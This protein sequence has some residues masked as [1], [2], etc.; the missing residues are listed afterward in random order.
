MIYEA[1]KSQVITKL[2]KFLANK[3]GQEESKSFIRELKTLQRE[4]NLPMSDI[5]DKD[6]KYLNAKK[7]LQIKSPENWTPS[8]NSM[9][10]DVYAFKFW[11][12]IEKGF[13]GK[14]GIGMRE[15]E[16]GKDQNNRNRKFNEKEL[17]FIKNK[18]NIKKG[19]LRPV[20]NYGTLRNGQDVIGIFSDY[21]DMDNLAKAR[22]YLEDNH[23]FAIQNV[24]SGG[25]PYAPDWRRFGDYSWSLGNIDSIGDDHNL[26]HTYTMTDEDLHVGDDIDVEEHDNPLNW[27]LPVDD[28]FLYNWNNYDVSIIENADFCIVFYIDDVIKRGYKKVTG[29]RSEREENRK[30]ATALYT[31][32]EV[33][34]L[35]IERY[36]DEIISRM[37][38]KVDSEYE[39]LKNLEKV[40]KFY[41]C[42]KYPVYTLYNNETA[43]ILRR[44][45]SDVKD[46]IRYKDS[47][48]FKILKERFLKTKKAIN[49][50]KG[51]YDKSE[52]IILDPNNNKLL[53]DVFK[54]IKEINNDINNYIN[55]QSIKTLSDLES[56]R[57]KLVYI[58]NIFK[59]ENTGRLYS[60]TLIRNMYD[61]VTIKEII[62][63]QNETKLKKD[64]EKLN[65]IKRYIKSVLN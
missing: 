32:K 31:D 26:L 27:N 40:L 36:M 39:D 43:D 37:G 33:K 6:I 49:T 2:N 63:I 15:V 53:L 48:E 56:I 52:K 13:L 19:K 42:G 18:L 24:A 23:I 51:V 38:I 47:Y 34:D 8:E 45:I 59:S 29:Y 61:P 5:Q 30:G 28:K 54:L 25:E 35:N 11:F 22:I 12:S 9:D 3:I 64:L 7:S 17:N 16:Y 4:F 20:E 1:F 41:I 50:Y 65:N 60:E 57:L 46:V 62:E 14:T 21:E 55:D 58:E 10:Y 44:F